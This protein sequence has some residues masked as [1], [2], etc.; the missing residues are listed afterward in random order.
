MMMI[1]VPHWTSLSCPI[2]IPPLPSR[3]P[4]SWLGVVL[5]VCLVL[6]LFGRLLLVCGGL[7][8]GVPSFACATLPCPHSGAKRLELRVD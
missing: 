8:I 6:F 1:Q 4:P 7:G 2:A 5:P 3:H